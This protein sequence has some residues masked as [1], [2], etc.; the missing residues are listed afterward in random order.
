MGHQSQWNYLPNLFAINVSYKCNG[1][2]NMSCWDMLLLTNVDDRLTDH[3]DC[4]AIKRAKQF[5]PLTLNVVNPP[6]PLLLVGQY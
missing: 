1:I 5:H 4:I 2:V 6:H 3:T